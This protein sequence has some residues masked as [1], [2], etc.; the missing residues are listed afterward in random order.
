[1]KELFYIGGGL[2]AGWIVG[3]I[4]FGNRL[5]RRNDDDEPR[6]TKIERGLDIDPVD[7]VDVNI[8]RYAWGTE[9]WSTSITGR[10]VLIRNGEIVG[11]VSG[12]GSVWSGY[13]FIEKRTVSVA[14]SITRVNAIGKVAATIKIMDYLAK[15]R[16]YAEV[17]SRSSRYYEMFHEHLVWRARLVSADVIA[18]EIGVPK[19]IVIETGVMLAEKGIIFGTIDRKKQ[20]RVVRRFEQIEQMSRTEMAQARAKR[21]GGRRSRREQIQIK[22]SR[23]VIAARDVAQMKKSGEL[24]KEEKRKLGRATHTMVIYSFALFGPDGSVGMFDTGDDLVKLARRLEWT[25]EELKRH[26]RRMEERAREEAELHEAELSALRQ[27]AI[28]EATKPQVPRPFEMTQAKAMAEMMAKPP[29]TYT[30]EFFE[31]QRFEG[32]DY[33]SQKSKER[34]LAI[35][36]V[37]RAQER[38]NSLR[39]KLDEAQGRKADAV[40]K[41]HFNRALQITASMEKTES[42]L[43]AA[44][45]ALDRAIRT[46]ENLRK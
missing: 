33:I 19:K 1:M 5:I 13:A 27:K 17:R 31:K 18:E 15:Q 3:K 38:V 35:R 28:I 7:R 6:H 39:I 42:D 43:A 10:F 14:T 26:A 9:V 16:D 4:L 44:M 11:Y 34:E 21:R 37:D 36:R 41:K 24:T 20:G 30:E 29:G 25:D 45:T 32:L 23:R 46:L 40:S 22:P 12:Y 2:A 8:P